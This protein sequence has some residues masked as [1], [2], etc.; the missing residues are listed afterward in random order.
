MKVPAE[1]SMKKIYNLGAR[2]VVLD[3]PTGSKLDMLKR[4][5][6]HGKEISCTII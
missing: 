1:L 6:R 2:S 3:L 5:N 4:Q